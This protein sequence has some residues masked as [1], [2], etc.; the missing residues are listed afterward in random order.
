ME[1]ESQTVRDAKAGERVHIQVQI[2]GADPF[3]AEEVVA[4]S[5]RT[6]EEGNYPHG[7]WACSTHPEAA[8]VHNMALASHTR[9]NNDCVIFW[10]CSEHGPE[11]P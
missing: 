4:D 3:K 5:C 7:G 9:D 11:T 8:L 1:Q 6:E 2:P 10:V